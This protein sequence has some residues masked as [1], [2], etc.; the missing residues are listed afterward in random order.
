MPMTMTTMVSTRNA[1]SLK[2]KACSTLARLCRVWA[3]SGGRGGRGVAAAAVASTTTT[4]AAIGA[5]CTA[6]AMAA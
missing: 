6:A 2:G 1:G 4:T 5:A 3:R